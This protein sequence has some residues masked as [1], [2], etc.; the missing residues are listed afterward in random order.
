MDNLIEQEPEIVR[1]SLQY[2]ILQIVVKFHLL[3]YVCEV[4][5]N[6]ISDL[7]SPD[8]MITW[9]SIIL[10]TS[11]NWHSFLNIRIFMLVTGIIGAVVAWKLE[12]YWQR[13]TP[14]N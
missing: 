2:W 12:P 10:A 1:H 6:L 4:I 14:E 8:E 9:Q 7:R 5:F 13:K 11:P 3:W